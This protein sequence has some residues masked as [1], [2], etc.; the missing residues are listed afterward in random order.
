[1][2]DL[3]SLL[4][5]S[6]LAKIQATVPPLPTGHIDRCYWEET[7]IGKFSLASAVNII[8]NNCSSTMAGVINWKQKWRWKGPQRAK[9]FLWLAAKERLMTNSLRKSR[10]LCDADSYP[11]V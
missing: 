6:V 9:F 8:T 11:R 4:P 3:D 10:G 7:S 2:Q 5:L 1:M